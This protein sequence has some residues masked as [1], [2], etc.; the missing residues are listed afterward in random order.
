MSLEE[1]HLNQTKT[2]TKTKMQGKAEQL[3]TTKEAELHKKGCMHTKRQREGSI[4]ATNTFKAPA[5]SMKEH[6]ACGASK[7][8]VVAAASKASAAA[9]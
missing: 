1:V 5:G 2:H 7:I 9:Y 4:D 3:S 6:G 8:R